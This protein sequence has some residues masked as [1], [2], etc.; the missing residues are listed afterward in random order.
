MDVQFTTTLDEVKKNLRV[1]KTAP[2]YTIVENFR[3]I[4]DALKAEINEL[5]SW[6]TDTA[7]DGVWKIDPAKVPRTKARMLVRSIFAFIEGIVYSMKQVALSADRLQNMLTE[8]E[9]EQMKSDKL[10]HFLPNVR[11][12]FDVL[13]KAFELSCE[14][15]TNCT[16]WN[17]MAQSVKLRNRLTHPK[18]PADLEL[19]DQELGWSIEA[20][21]WFVAQVQGVV[22]V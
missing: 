12:A 9:K 14:L 11:L 13:G 15:N 1:F 17:R 22:A 21:S 10:H 16:G 4:E 7:E 19:T 18:C 3:R 5:C 2:E 20:Y 6:V 8:Q